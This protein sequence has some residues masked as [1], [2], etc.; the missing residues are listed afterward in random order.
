MTTFILKISVMKGRRPAYQLKVVRD[1]ILC[2]LVDI[3][4]SQSKRICQMAV[5]ILLFLR[6]G[7]AY[8]ILIEFSKK[9]YVIRKEHLTLCSTFLLF[10]KKKKLNMSVMPFHPN[11]VPEVQNV[12]GGVY[13]HFS[14][15][16]K[17]LK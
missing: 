8:Q 4:L 10:E 6:E 7:F 17:K 14:A 5:A 11:Q 2:L 9:F 15:L 1:H 3:C 16:K 12:C 13:K